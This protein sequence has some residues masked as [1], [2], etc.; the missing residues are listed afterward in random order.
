MAGGDT[1]LLYEGDLQFVEFPNSKENKQGRN[2]TKEHARHQQTLSYRDL[3]VSASFKRDGC[4][5]K[6]YPL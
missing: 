5:L 2:K 1:K 4:K 3:L 6:M